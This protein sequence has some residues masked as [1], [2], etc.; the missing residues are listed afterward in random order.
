MADLLRTD[1]LV[2]VPVT[3]DAARAVVDAVSALPAAPGWPGDDAVE[4]LRAA[5]EYGGDL[6]WFVTLDGVVIGDCGTHGE[7]GGVVEIRYAI[8]PP[9]RRRGHATEVVAALTRW[10]SGQPGVRQVVA[11]RVVADNVASRRTL[12][13]CGFTVD[14]VD[15]RH[16]SYVLHYSK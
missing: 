11:R 7:T 4:G 15:G 9:Y 2:L 14:E 1:R 6:G 12:E 10:L 3:A 13:R 16:V 5:L 8:A